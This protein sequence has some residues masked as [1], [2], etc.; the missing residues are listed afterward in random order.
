M[1]G[2]DMMGLPHDSSH[3]CRKHHPMIQCTSDSRHFRH[4]RR[5]GGWCG[6]TRTWAADRRGSAR[7]KT[8][9]LAIYLSGIAYIA[10]D[11]IVDLYTGEFMFWKVWSKTQTKFL[12]MIE[13]MMVHSSYC[14]GTCCRKT[15]VLASPSK[16]IQWNSELLAPSNCTKWHQSI[17]L[18]F[19]RSKQTP[20]K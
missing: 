15:L 9:F 13:F 1:T 14:Q 17:D 12:D 16:P 10:H 20:E 6:A 11:G 2:W 8:G 3:S 5:C 18:T 19:K 7:W 4:R